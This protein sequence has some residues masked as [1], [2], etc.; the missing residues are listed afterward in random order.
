MQNNQPM[1]ALLSCIVVFLAFYILHIAQNVVIPLI[2]ALLIWALLNAMADGINGLLK[3]R[4][5]S[6]LCKCF[7]MIVFIGIVWI[8]VELITQ[9]I[10][11]LVEAAP[12]YQANFDKRIEG[13]LHIIGLQKDSVVQKIIHS[14][15]IPA[16][17]SNSAQAITTLFSNAFIIMI[18]IIFMLTEQ[19]SFN[20]KV[21]AL[22]K[23]KTSLKNVKKTLN[24]I[25][26][27]IQTYV[28]VKSLLSFTTAF[29]SYIIL[30]FVGLDFAAFW[31]LLI[32]L[33]NFIPN[34][35]SILA[36][37]LPAILSLVQYDSLTPFI[38]VLST[39]G[40]IQFLVGN[41]I[42]PRI[43][44]NSLNLSSLIII[45]SLVTWGSLWGIAGAFLCVPLMVIL[46]IIF[47]SFP[48]TR[49]V[50]IIL[51]KDG[52]VEPSSNS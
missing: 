34:I 4:L 10:P 52:S 40:A 47:A 1:I 37:A 42:E 24:T 48:A 5:P 38:M 17:L 25:Y 46:K 14:V 16:L 7:A 6:W 8:P 43:M 26:E 30:K 45:L 36:T 35:G 50:A 9:S 39:I 3:N 15:D 22:F 44:G 49:F 51:S 21:A 20:H 33:L 28:W 41:V 11:K 13:L 27:R 18:Y 31:A 19:H 2:V 12:K 23:K 29:L 32:F